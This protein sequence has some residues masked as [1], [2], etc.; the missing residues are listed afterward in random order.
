LVASAFVAEKED[1]VSEL[2]T[3]CVASGSIDSDAVAEGAGAEAVTSDD[4]CPHAARKSETAAKGAIKGI[5]IDT[6]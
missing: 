3:G 5:F 6:L 2:S 4:F 1:T